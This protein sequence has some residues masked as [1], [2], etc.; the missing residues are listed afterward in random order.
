MGIYSSDSIIKSINCYNITKHKKPKYPVA[1]F[2]T[3]KANKPGNHCWSFLNIYQKKD[4]LL[5][6]SFGF[7]GFKQFIVDN[8]SFIIDKILYNLKKK[9]NKKG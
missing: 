6:D 3:D 2:N 8:D 1:I 4:L 9:I 5:F 7:V